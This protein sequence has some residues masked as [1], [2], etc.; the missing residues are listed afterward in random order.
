MAVVTVS[1]MKTMSVDST[2]LILPMVPS[3][4]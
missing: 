2:E 3:V 1:S 4:K